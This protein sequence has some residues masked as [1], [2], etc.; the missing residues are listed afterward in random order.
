MKIVSRR[1][2]MAMP[3]GTVYQTYE[4]CVFGTIRVKAQTIHSDGRAI[5]WFE[6]C[7]ISTPDFEDCHH[8]GD[9]LDACERME[10]GENV[11]V[12]VDALCRDGMFADDQLYAVWDSEDV[13]RLV[14][15]LQGNIPR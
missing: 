11:P 4:P 5:D 15:A 7:G 12:A 6:V 13:A 3:A 2:L 14:S 1:A 9:F 10:R 8:A